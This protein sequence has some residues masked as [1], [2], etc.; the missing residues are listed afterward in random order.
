ME[1]GFDTAGYFKLLFENVVGKR[2]GLANNFNESLTLKRMKMMK[3]NV[4]HATCVGFILW[5]CH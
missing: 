2:F 1:Q 3:K 5:L 4:R